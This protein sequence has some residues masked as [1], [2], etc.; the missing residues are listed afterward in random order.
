M[1]ARCRTDQSTNS[2]NCMTRPCRHCQ[3][4]TA[5]CFR[6]SARSVCTLLTPWYDADCPASRRKTRSLERHHRRSGTDAD[7][8]AWVKQL[9]AMHVLYQ[10]K[11]RQYWRRK[12]AESSGNMNKKLSYRRV[13][14]QCVLSVV[15]LPIVTQQCR[16]YLYEKS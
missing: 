4:S 11:D 8:L 2:S 13:T 9:K 10:E 16:N 7:R 15:I 1:Q 12:I 5:R 6:L 14:A 3:I